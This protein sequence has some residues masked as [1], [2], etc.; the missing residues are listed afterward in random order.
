MISRKFK[1]TLIL[2]ALIALL[3]CC[4]TVNL[5]NLGDVNY[6]PSLAVP[7]GN[8]NASMYDIINYVDQDFLEADTNTNIVYYIWKENNNKIKF[9][10]KDFSYGGVITST[11]NLID[12]S[13]FAEL[14]SEGKNTIPA[15]DHDFTTSS[16]YEFKYNEHTDER[17]VEVDSVTIAS[18]QFNCDIKINGISLSKDNWLEIIFVFPNI[19][20]SENNHFSIKMTSNTGRLRK[21]MNN[22]T[23]YFSDDKNTTNLQVLYTL[24]SNGSLTFTPDINVK[25]TTKINIIDV[26]A[27][28]GYFWQKEAITNDEIKAE[29]PSDIFNQDLFTSNNLLFSNPEIYMTIKNN[30][31]IPVRLKV[32]E[33]YA[34]AE[35]GNKY[36]A[37]F[38]GNKS[39][40]IDVQRAENPGDIAKTTVKFDRENGK[41]YQLFEEFPK[42]VHYIW[43]IFN[44]N[45]ETTH[46]QFAI[47]PI[48]LNMDV[49]VRL[50]LQ[51][52]PTSE[53]S[54][55]DTIEA[56]FSGM[57]DS[58]TIPEQI[59]IEL[60]NLHLDIQNGL[61]VTIN[62]IFEFLDEND[63][64]VYNTDSITIASATINDEGIAQ[65]HSDSHILLPFEGDDIDMLFKTKKIKLS[66]KVTGFDK[67]SKIDIRANNRLN[68]HLSAFAKAKAT[69]D[70]D[71]I[72]NNK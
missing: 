24:H 13:I 63:N 52:N 54:Y 33:V 53:V 25:Y 51:F 19:K 35:S 41:T 6:N 12:N 72:M 10:L 46:R 38:N 32:D 49:E 61:P 48:D 69:F 11:E 4:N 42:E 26:A 3:P 16:S 2:C 9:N 17:V 66:A 20:N 56:D 65:L 1:S 39:Y 5:N 31:G 62:G 28:Y 27:I 64:I 44:D 14:S 8:F 60:I 21:E 55:Q 37:D 7:I 40:S 34:I 58:G 70:L 50:P 18:A 30:M 57:A 23:A 43:Q 67:E 36:Y 68:I 29:I 22:F 71:S 47:S 15:G 45:T 59:N